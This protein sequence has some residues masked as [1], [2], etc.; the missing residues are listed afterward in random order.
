MEREE[1]LVAL[2]VCELLDQSKTIPEIERAYLS[3][4]KILD[5]YNRNLEKPRPRA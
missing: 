1:M 2:T 3:A 4:V 5:R